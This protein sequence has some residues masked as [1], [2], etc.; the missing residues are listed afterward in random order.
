[1]SSYNKILNSI[2]N[3]ETKNKI[4]PFT[5]ILEYAAKEKIIPKNSSKEIIPK[6]SKCKSFSNKTNKNSKYIFLNIIIIKYMNYRII[7]Y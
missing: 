4:I 5:K 7:I 1:M 3:C 2:T 6:D